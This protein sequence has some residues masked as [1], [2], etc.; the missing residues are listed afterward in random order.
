LTAAANCFVNRTPQ[1]SGAQIAP[2]IEQEIGADARGSTV[3]K[4]SV[5]VSLLI[6]CDPQKKRLNEISPQKNS[7]DELLGAIRF[8]D[9]R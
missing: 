6:D 4:V 9:R 1:K 3:N 8:P 5:R 2:L 7:R